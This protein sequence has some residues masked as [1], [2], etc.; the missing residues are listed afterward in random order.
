MARRREREKEWT[1]EV[2][3]ERE[4]DEGEGGGVTDQDRVIE[5]N[6]W[7][8]ARRTKNKIL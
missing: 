8:K 1:I 4:R 7:K 2:E 3:R 6:V 5:T